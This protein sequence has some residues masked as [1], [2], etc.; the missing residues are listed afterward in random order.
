[1]VLMTREPYHLLAMTRE[2]YSHAFTNVLKLAGYKE[3]GEANQVRLREECRQVL[4][5]H[6]GRESE[7]GATS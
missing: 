4:K 7:Q 3:R 1:M 5:Q 2:S 6:V